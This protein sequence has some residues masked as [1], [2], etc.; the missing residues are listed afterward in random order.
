M[1]IAASRFVTVVKSFLVM[2][3][4]FTLFLFVSLIPWLIAVHASLLS[5]QFYDAGWNYLGVAC[6]IFA[7]G[8]ALLTAVAT[9]WIFGTCLVM[10]VRTIRGLETEPND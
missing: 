2:L 7:I 10:L 1:S 4:T 6:K 9:V 5:R 8:L 3:F